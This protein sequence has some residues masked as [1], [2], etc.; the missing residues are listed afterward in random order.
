MACQG[1]A[2]FGIYLGRYIRW[3]SWSIMTQPMILTRSL[4]TSL[5]D[6]LAQKV[7]LTYGFGLATLYVSF[8][9]YVEKDLAVDRYSPPLHRWTGH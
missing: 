6:P 8:Y 1:L 4:W 7:A 2:G 5:H 9:I 3:N